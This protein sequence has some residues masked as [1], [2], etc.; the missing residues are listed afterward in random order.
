MHH[1]TDDSYNN[2]KFS[3]WS[4]NFWQFGGPHCTWLGVLNTVLSGGSSLS[5][6]INENAESS[7]GLPFKVNEFVSVSTFISCGSAILE[8][9]HEWLH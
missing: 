6:G 8:S 1:E 3:T 7:H 4:E 5:I 9:G 2:N